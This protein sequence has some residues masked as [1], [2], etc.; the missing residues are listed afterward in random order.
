MS[1][2]NKI[3]FTKQTPCLKTIDIIK[4]R[5]ERQMLPMVSIH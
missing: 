4:Q 1:E 2:I 5:Q 3:Q